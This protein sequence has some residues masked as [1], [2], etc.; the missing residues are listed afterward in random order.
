MGFFNK[1]SGK[2]NT[3]TRKNFIKRLR[4][5]YRISFYNETTYD[6]VFTLRLSRLN[7]VVVS[8]LISIILITVTIILLI[9]TPLIYLIP[10]YPSTQTK[11]NMVRNVM[12]LDSL[13]K[14]IK[15]WTVY[16][17]NLKLILSGKE[18]ILVE[19]LSDTAII[20]RYK[21]I[22]LE[23]SMEDSL[24]RRTIEELERLNDGNVSLFQNEKIENK[25]FFTPFRGKKKDDINVSGGKYYTSFDLSSSETVFSILGGTVLSIEP[26]GNNLFTVILQ[27]T[28]Q[29]ISIYRGLGSV[30][31]TVGSPISA[32]QPIANAPETSGN[33]PVVIQFELWLDGKVVN[34]F[35]YIKF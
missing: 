6:E 30:K 32:G 33:K 28:D 34:P 31:V 25:T 29:I 23:S 14:Q 20:N 5:K 10:G 15:A 9:Y 27:H 8:T 13:E 3:E 19:D 1:H 35:D 24:F 16:N 22:A 4:N 21:N 2:Q 11:M 17:E 18:P 12:R 26:L 7:V